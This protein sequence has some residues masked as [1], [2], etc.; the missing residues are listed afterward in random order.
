MPTIYV[1]NNHVKIVAQDKLHIFIIYLQAV[2]IPH[3]AISS[4]ISRKSSS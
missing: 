2:A 1:W 4:K 3:L